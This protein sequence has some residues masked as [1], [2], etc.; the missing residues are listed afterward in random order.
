R[1]LIDD[2]LARDL[3]LA[4]ADDPRRHGQPN[5]QAGGLGRTER[6]E[7]TRERIRSHPFA[8][9]RNRNDRSVAIG[10]RQLEASLAA[11][12]HGFDRV[13]AEVFEHALEKTRIAVKVHARRRR[14]PVA[15]FDVRPAGARAGRSFFHE[16]LR[17]DQNWSELDRLVLG[18]ALEQ[19]Q[20]PL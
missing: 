9:V 5:A 15:D 6:L 8:A 4:F 1:S 12:L 14:L 20:A 3:A 18:E 16:L 10:N 13:L 11:T 2:A 17:I 19:L 7:Q